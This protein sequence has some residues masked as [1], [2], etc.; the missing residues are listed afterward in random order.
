VGDDRGRE[1]EAEDQPADDE[2]LLVV[3]LAKHG[4]VDMTA[5]RSLAAIVTTPWK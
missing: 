4:E 5:F 2:E 1:R 3:L